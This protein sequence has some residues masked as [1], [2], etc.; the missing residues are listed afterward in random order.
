MWRERR[1]DR[2]RRDPGG[3]W[4][5]SELEGLNLEAVGVK[6]DKREGVQVNEYLQTTNPRIY[7]AGDICLKY[8]FTHTAD[9]TAPHRHPECSISWT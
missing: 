8:K 4:Q 1:R 5:I 2:G 6:Y 3:S 9:A 7:A